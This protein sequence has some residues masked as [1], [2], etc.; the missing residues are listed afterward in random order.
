MGRR[1]VLSLQESTGVTRDRPGDSFRA[2]AG[3]S[4]GLRHR[5]W[6]AGNARAW[7]KNSRWV[8][9]HGRGRSQMQAFGFL[10]FSF[11]AGKPYPSK[12]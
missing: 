12:S 7:I 5:E 8:T 9:N 3:I 11:V 10:F 2:G 4:S 6:E 1:L